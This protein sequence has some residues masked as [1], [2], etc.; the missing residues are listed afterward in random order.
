MWQPTH[1]KAKENQ[2]K[3]FNKPYSDIKISTIYLRPIETEEVK[4]ILNRNKVSESDTEF[5]MNEIRTDT[6]YEDQTYLNYFIQF[7]IDNHVKNFCQLDILEYT[8]NLKTLNG[9]SRHDAEKEALASIR[10]R[11]NSTG[12]QNR[13]Q[14][15][16]AACE[17]T[18]GSYTAE[19]ILSMTSE[20]NIILPNMRNTVCYALDILTSANLKTYTLFCKMFERYMESSYNLETLLELTWD[21]IEEGYRTKFIATYI[22]NICCYEFCSI[23]FFYVIPGKFM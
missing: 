23:A 21:N 8:A 14:E 12:N 18:N 10:N 2:F 19:T 3:I 15:Y 17:I 20:D 16:L 6:I 7:Y 22:I 9:I 13:L 1:D 11:I 5:I 4:E